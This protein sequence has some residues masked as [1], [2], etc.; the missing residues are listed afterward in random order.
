MTVAA[1]PGTMSAEHDGETVYFCSEGCREE[2][3]RR[4]EHVGD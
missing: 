1:V 3:T 2:F 4:H